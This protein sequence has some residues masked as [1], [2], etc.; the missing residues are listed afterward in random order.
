MSALPAAPTTGEPAHHTAAALPGV[1]RE[2]ALE[3]VHLRL[4]GGVL[5]R[6]PHVTLGLLGRHDQRIAAHLDGLAIA[7]RAGVAARDEQAAA[8]GADD[9]GAVFTPAALA[10]LRHEHIAWHALLEPLDS[11]ATTPRWRGLLSALGWVS[12]TGVDLSAR[13][14]ESLEPRASVEAGDDKTPP[15][16]LD[17]D[18]SLPWPDAA[19]VQAWWQQQRAGLLDAGAAAGGRLLADRP[20]DAATAAHLLAH[21]TQRLRAHAALLH[22]V[23]RPQAPLL[24]VAAPAWRQ[25]RWITAD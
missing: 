14:L 20:R 8:D 5:V 15:I 6:A 17:E 4:Q 2:H 19:R 11:A 21:G 25:R 10:L 3:A 9:V 7:G 1:L 24:P 12:A 13:G 22:A 23:L 18:D 16:D